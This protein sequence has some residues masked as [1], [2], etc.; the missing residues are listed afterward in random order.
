MKIAQELDI[1]NLSTLHIC[2]H[3]RLVVIEDR[4]GSNRN[5]EIY[6]MEIENLANLYRAL[7]LTMPT[8]LIQLE[9]ASM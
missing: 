6:R 1:A 3:S 5:G 2:L 4:L 8:R 9:S 7:G